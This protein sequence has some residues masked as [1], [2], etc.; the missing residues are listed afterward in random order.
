MKAKRLGTALAAAALTLAGLSA[1]YG[2][3][4][5]NAGAAPAPALSAGAKVAASGHSR[6]GAG[7]TVNLSNLPSTRGPA[8]V[9]HVTLGKNGK[10]TGSGLPSRASTGTKPGTTATPN[11]ATPPKSINAGFDGISQANS[12]CNCQPSDVNAAVGPNHIVE[13]VNTTLAVFT[14]SGSL[15]KNTSLN[16][17]FGVS[18]AMSDP[19][20]LYDPVW[21]RYVLNAISADFSGTPWIFLAISS[22]GDPTGGWIT[23]QFTYNGS[24]QGGVLD[25]PMMGMD[26]DAIT[27]TT[28]NYSCPTGGCYTGSTAFSLSKAR[29]YNGF[30]QGF[31]T[32]GVPFGTVPTIVGGYPSDQSNVD[33]FL[34]PDDAGNQM[35]VYYMTH[36]ARSPV[37]TF[38]GAIPYSFSAPTRRVNQ[39]GTSQTL[40]PSDG[41]IPWATTQLGSLV[42]FAHGVN[43]GG[44]PAVNYGYVNA[45]AMTISTATAFH[46][47]TSDDFNPSIS[48]QYSSNGIKGALSWAYTDTAANT[49]VTPSF[50]LFG[51]TSPAH[52]TGAPFRTGGS[53]TTF[54]DRFGDYSSAVPEFNSVGACP[55]GVNWMVANQFFGPDGTWRTRIDRLSLGTC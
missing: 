47:S 18:N 55:I 13:A 32:F 26:E 25:Y 27:M 50:A 3:D 30:G 43:L 23:Y 5:P 38:K 12:N 41:R 1:T 21:N 46:S 17:F 15:L 9:D 48:V 42:W 16:S 22:T 31:S 2:A 45:G 4:A 52:L 29:M 10:P 19:H 40:D 8:R 51:G 14:K 11:T 53:S 33:Y 28:N 39:P 34:S 24:P 20:V 49:P 6:T 35:K 54:Q 36:S 37:F 7:T 44:F